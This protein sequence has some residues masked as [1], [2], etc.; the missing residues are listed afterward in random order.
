MYIGGEIRTSHFYFM[1]R[2]L[3][4]IDWIELLSE[5]FV[6]FFLKLK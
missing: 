5:D 1:S 4:L 2:G 3:Q 6:I